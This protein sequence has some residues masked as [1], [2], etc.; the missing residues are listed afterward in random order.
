[1][2]G[3]ALPSARYL[4]EQAVFNRIVLRTVWWIVGDQYADT[5]LLGQLDQILLDDVVGAGIRAA[6]VTEQ[7]QRMGLGVVV[8]QVLDPH[9]PQVVAGELG[10]VAVGAQGHVALIG[11]DVI[12]AVGNDPAI[13]EAGKVV[14]IDP[15]ATCRV[16]LA[17]PVEVAQHFL[18]LGV[19][20]QHGQV[21]LG[22]GRTVAADF[23]E[24]LVALLN[25]LHIVHLQ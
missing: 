9:T 11:V 14:V 18:L 12:N 6:T 7:Q 20:A 22:E 13:R 4:G 2:E 5:E 8:L 17:R 1:M 16:A 19:D 3:H 21:L 25:L 23:L 15:A 24:L 10:G